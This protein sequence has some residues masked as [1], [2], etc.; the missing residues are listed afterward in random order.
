MWQ[1]GAAP[2]DLRI[3]V[4]KEVFQV[5]AETNRDDGLQDTSQRGGLLVIDSR[6]I[7]MEKRAAVEKQA[8]RP[9]TGADQ[10]EGVG[11]MPIFRA[12]LGEIF[13][14]TLDMPQ[15]GIGGQIKWSRLE[16]PGTLVGVSL[17]GGV[18]SDGQFV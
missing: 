10:A 4:R 11:C 7:G 13:R 9:P 8:T 12:C 2:V 15:C 17:A 16:P 3:D 18:Q 14:A 6:I 5:D 1:L